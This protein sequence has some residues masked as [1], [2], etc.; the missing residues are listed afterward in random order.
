[1]GKGGGF[2]NSWN[3]KRQKHIKDATDDLQAVYERSLIDKK[4]VDWNKEIARV[5]EVNYMPW[6]E[7][8][9]AKMDSIGLVKKGKDKIANAN[10]VVIS[11]TQ[12]K[13]TWESTPGIT[14]LEEFVID[15]VTRRNAKGG[16]IINAEQ[17]KAM[18]ANGGRMRTM[19]EAFAAYKDV[20][21]Q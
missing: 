2:I 14:T 19:A 12:G 20:E 8:F 18:F 13:S 11:F 3:E 17:I 10:G 1:M 16:V 15:Q 6:D 21:L 4:P 5:Q 7:Q 9:A